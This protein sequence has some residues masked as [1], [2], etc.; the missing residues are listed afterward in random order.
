MYKT[1][2]RAREVHVRLNY[3]PLILIHATGKWIIWRRRQ[4]DKTNGN[5]M[6]KNVQ[7]ER[8]Y[9]APGESHARWYA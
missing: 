5:E 9:W 4:D 7:N 2:V 6:H 1:H 3:M 8:P